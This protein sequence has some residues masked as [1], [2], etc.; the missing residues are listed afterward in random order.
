MDAENHT[1]WVSEN[2]E[3]M[4]TIIIC[5]GDSAIAKT[6]DLVDGD[7]TANALWKE[8]ERIYTISFT[9]AIANLQ[10]KREA[11]TFKDGDDWERHISSFVSIINELAAQD[12]AFIDAE[13]V[14]KILRTL[15]ESFVSLAMAS[16]LNENSFDQIVNAAQR[17]I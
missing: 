10:G 2:A 5:L 8:L 7:G 15:P 11:L 12:Q 13:K 3:S 1:E 16:S 17:N 4:S 14:T 9:Q 6:R